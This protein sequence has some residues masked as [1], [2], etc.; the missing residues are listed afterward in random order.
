MSEKLLEVKD[1]FIEYATDFEVV[2]AVNGISFS[3]NAGETI[4]LVGETGAGKTTTALGI[5]GL[6]PEPPGRIVSGEILLRGT[7]LLAKSAKDMQK[8]R[9]KEISMIFQDPM[10]SLNPVITVGDQIMEVLRLHEKCSREEAGNKAKD[11]LELVGISG[12]RFSDYPHQF[13]GGMKQ[14]VMIAIALS[15]NPGLLIADEPTTALDV[16][17]Q[18]Q[19]LDLLNG[20]KE[21]YNTSVIMITHDLGVVAEVCDRVIIMYAG[22]IMEIGTIKDVYTNPLHPYTVGLFGSLP[23]VEE[24]VDRLNAIKGLMPDPSNLPCGCKF[25]PRCSCRRKE[26]ESEE[27]QLIE[28]TPGHFVRCGQYLHREEEAYDLLVRGKRA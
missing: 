24:E 4:G 2:R 28:V 13:S 12:D 25:H 23:D 6:V 17:I 22:Y 8:I 16:T 26:C 7:N 3:L 21:K 5:L 15:C 9:G 1:L 10:T 19:V 11:M 18:A 27:R 14:R 20:L